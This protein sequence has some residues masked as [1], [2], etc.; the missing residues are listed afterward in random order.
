MTF[1]VLS[2]AFGDVY[3][4]EGFSQKRLIFIREYLLRS[5]NEYRVSTVNYGT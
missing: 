2:L 4:V 1:I 5:S 3:D